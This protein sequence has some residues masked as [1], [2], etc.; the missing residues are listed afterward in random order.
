MNGFVQ[1][2]LSP[3]SSWHVASMQQKLLVGAAGAGA[4]WYLY[5]RKKDAWA[6]WK[7]I[8]AAL[9]VSYATSMLLNAAGQFGAS[10]PQQ[11]QMAAPAPAVAPP[12]PSPPAGSQGL[13]EPSGGVFE[14]QSMPTMDDNLGSDV[15]MD[16]DGGDEGIFD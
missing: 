14:P 12:A 11:P 16:E 13:P 15:P 8:A 3:L 4:G 1:W 5:T 2:L 10:A 6:T 7:I 9:G